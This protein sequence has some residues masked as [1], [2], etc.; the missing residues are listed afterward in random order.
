MG[1]LMS[2]DTV[3][4][5][6]CRSAR[7]VPCW[8]GSV[9]HVQA[10]TGFA[11]TPRM[12]QNWSQRTTNDSVLVDAQA[13]LHLGFLDMSGALGRRFGSL[14][15]SIDAFRTRLRV[16]PAA[17][18]SATG[19]GAGRAERYAAQILDR[20][21]VDGGVDI[22]LDEAIPDHL[23]LGSG[24]QMALAIGRAVGACF[25][26]DTSTREI[27]ALLQRGSRSGIGI[28]AFDQGGFLMDSGVGNDGSVPPVTARLA[29]PDHWRV[30]LVMDARGQGLHG[31][32]EVEAFRR[33]PPFPQDVAA[34]LCHLTLMQILPGLQEGALEPV[35]TGIAELQRRVGDHFAPAQGGRFTS[36]AVADALSWAE[37]EGFAGVGQSSWG[38]TGF[39][40]LPDQ[41]HADTLIRQARER[42]GE[43]S[44]LRFIVTRGCNQGSHI[45]I[46]SAA[47]AVKEAN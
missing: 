11:V 30:L 19:P 5:H 28:G 29:F 42:F 13:R 43:L 47:N 32:Q 22:S 2:R 18:T 4:R 9:A 39:V 36:P 33:L 21:G 41:Q 46:E 3:P 37:A 20:L 14:G 35:A 27:A 12:K 23:G 38:P 15:L 45:Q 31:K 1:A 10:G 40:L 26:I 34:H 8:P 25:D 24:T 7:S 16:R 44:P 6:G 17:R